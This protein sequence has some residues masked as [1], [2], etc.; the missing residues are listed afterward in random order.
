M[1]GKSVVEGVWGVG[2]ASMCVGAVAAIHA[3]AQHA[4]IDACCAELKMLRIKSTDLPV[5]YACQRIAGNVLARKDSKS[6]SERVTRNA[7]QRQA[8]GLQCQ[9]MATRTSC[10]V[11]SHG[12]DTFRN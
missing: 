5:G 4:E 9:K 2:A 11:S 1:H 7:R 3:A 8:I 10:T 6:L 12:W